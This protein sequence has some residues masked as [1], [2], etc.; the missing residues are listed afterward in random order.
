M[1]REG[2]WYNGYSWQERDELLVTY[3]RL[4]AAGQLAPPTG[5][6]DICSDPDSVVESHS[7]DYSRPYRWTPPAA[8]DLCTYCHRRQLHGRFRR[9]DYWAAFLAH[10]R[11]GGYASDLQNP[12]VRLEFEYYRLASKHGQ[13]AALYPLRPYTKAPGKEWFARLRMDIESLRDPAARPR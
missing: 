2:G 6:C 1:A 11:R 10:V 7:E 13:R 5:P 9:P 3:K 8:Y 12:T 4:I